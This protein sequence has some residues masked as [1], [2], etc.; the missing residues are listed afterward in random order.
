[1]FYAVG[2]IVLVVI[3]ILIAHQINNWNTNRKLQQVEIKTLTELKS[4]LDQCF[5]DIKADS[6]GFHRSKQANESILHHMENNITYH[7]SL[8]PSFRNLYHFA[9]FSIVRTTYD[10]ISQTGSNIISNDSMCLMISDIYDRWMN[11]YKELEERYLEE[12]YTSFIHPMTISQLKLNENN[13]SIPR[14][15]EAFGKS[16]TNIQAMKFSQNMFQQMMNYQHTLMNEIQKV[17]DEIDMEI[18]RLR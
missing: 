17:I 5:E 6:T 3:G 7:D 16:N 8:I 1:M 11:L 13:V 15:F 9:T 10:N 4:D 14:D 12:H 18:E 2:I